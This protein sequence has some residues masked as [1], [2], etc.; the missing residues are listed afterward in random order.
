MR[1]IAYLASVAAMSLFVLAGCNNK[2]ESA[3]N[4][5]KGLDSVKT[6]APVDS[7]GKHDT[8]MSAYI[9]YVDSQQILA[10]YT[11]AVEVAKADSAA[12]IQLAAYNNQLSSGLQRRQQQIQEKLQRNGYLSEASYNADVASL[13]KAQ[14]DAENKFTQRQ[15]DY[16]QDLMLKQ[17]ELH[18]SVKS[19][20]DFICLKYNLDAVLEKSAGLYFNP[21]L[22]MTAEVLDE[23]NR[24][25]TA[26][27]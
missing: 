1:K 4:S 2:S 15:R 8:P 24:R 18:D 25:Y 21:A 5:G 3:N 17:Q 20:V 7:T 23:L 10:N 6:D 11:L 16:A 12:Q 9:R 27:K 22:D 13:Q 19:V 14:Q 26:S